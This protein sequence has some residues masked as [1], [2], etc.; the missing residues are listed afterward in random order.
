MSSTTSNTPRLGPQQPR[1]PGFQRRDSWSEVENQI[2]KKAVERHGVSK[3]DAVAK[4]IWTGKSPEACRAR[5]AQLVPQLHDSWLASSANKTASPSPRSRT[6]TA[7]S[8][9]DSSEGNGQAGKIKRRA[10]TQQHTRCGPPNQ[11]PG[12]RYGNWYETD[13]VAALPPGSGSGS[14]IT[15]SRSGSVSGSASMRTNRPALPI[16]PATGIAAPAPNFMPLPKMT[17]SA[18]PIPIQIPRERRNTE[19]VLLPNWP[20]N[21]PAAPRIANPIPNAPSTASRDQ[22]GSTS[23][24]SSREREWRA[25]HPLMTPGSGSKAGSRVGSRETSRDRG[26]GGSSGSIAGPSSKN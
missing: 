26:T 17:P 23:S 2:L 19:P 25:P 21:Q 5:W 1:S 12:V 24:T 4:M 11:H 16:S 10:S 9:E 8:S 20:C 14:S 7:S 18:M 22:R 3:W 15:P 13:V 6:G